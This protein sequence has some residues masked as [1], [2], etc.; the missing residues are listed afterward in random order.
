MGHRNRMGRRA[1]VEGLGSILA[2]QPARV[3]GRWRMQLLH[4]DDVAALSS[5]W[6]KIGG[7]FQR[8]IT[9]LNDGHRPQPAEE[10]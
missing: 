8:A 5:D 2:I 1:F 6:Q 7:D 9:L 10:R 3:R 4:K